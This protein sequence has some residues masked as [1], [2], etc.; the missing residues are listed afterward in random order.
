[1]GDYEYDIA[2]T[3]CEPVIENRRLVHV[4]ECLLDLFPADPDIR[5]LGASSYLGVPLLDTDGEILGHLALLDT[6][7]LPEDPRVTAIFNIFAGRAAAELRR[8][9]RDRDL[10]DR[11]QKLSRFLDSAMDAVLEL[12][13]KLRLSAVN[14]AAETVLGA[15]AARLIGRPIAEFLSRESNG[16]LVYLAGNLKGKA[17]PRPALSIPDGLDAVRAGGETFPAE[18]TLS[19][20]TAGGRSFFALIL[21]DV[22]ERL[23]AETRIRALLRETESLRS[24]LATAHGFEEIL[25]ES[26]SL[27]RVL[28]DVEKVAPMDTTVLLTGET[29]TGKELIARAIHRRSTRADGPMV[30]VNC[31][32]IPE[33]LQESEFFGHE[34]GAFTGATQQREGRFRLADGGTIF[35][36]EVGELPADLQ[37]KLLR[38]LQEG[39]FETVGGNVTERVDVRVVAATN[40]DLDAM[41]EDGTF[42]RDLLYRLNVFPVRVPALRERDDDVIL[43][44]RSFAERLAKDR[45]GR[46][47]PLSPEARARLRRYDWPGNIRELQNVIERAWITSTDGR[48]L[49]LERALPDVPAERVAVASPT[50]AAADSRVLTETELRDLERANLLRALDA[51]DGKI[52]GEGGAAELVGLNPNTFTSRLKSLGIER[53][54]P[55]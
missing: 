43:L 29:G 19:R 17:E 20:Y 24:E 42:R 12:D 49:N 14:R 37:A 21:R 5:E 41:V 6:K 27:R 40:R 9:R 44:A 25:G 3:P 11:E 23:E 7:P 16:K 8:L 35:L 15:P 31:A 46:A 13:E 32:A 4:P 54:R 45:G 50:E 26:E 39:E 48:T 38:V 1:H 2:G 34:K 51:A 33:G 36:D 55:R 30:K 53:P 28:A 52:S 18:A 47:V 10:R 22:D